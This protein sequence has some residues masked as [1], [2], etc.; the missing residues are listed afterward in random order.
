MVLIFLIPDVQTYAAKKITKNLNESYGTEISL[1]RLKINI[2]TDIDLE[3]ALVLDHKKDTLLF[4]EQISTSIFNI[5]NLIS[6]NNLDLSSTDIDG[7][8]FNLV[9]YQNE[10]SNNLSQ[11]LDKLSKSDQPRKDSKPF[12]LHIDD[13]VLLNSDVKIINYKKEN[14]ELFTISD[15]MLDLEDVNIVEG[16]ISIGINSL[17]GFTGFGMRVERLK[18][19]F[20]FTKNEM[21][22]DNLDLKTPYSSISTDLKFSFDK[23]DWSD[24]ENKVII[25]ADFEND[26]IST[27]DLYLFYTEFG[28]SEKLFVSGN[29]NGPL[30]DFNLNNA[31]IAGIQRSS[32]KGNLQFKNL[33]DAEKFIFDT[34]YVDITT[35]YYDLKRLLPNILGESLP[36]FIKY[37]GNF[38]VKGSTRLKSVDLD[39]DLDL[40]SS[41]GNGDIEINFKNLN[42]S[43]NVE[44]EGRL[45]LEQFNLG[46]VSQT[47]ALGLS[48]FNVYVKGKGFTQESLDTEVVG[49]IK[50]IGINNYNYT[51]IDIDGN[52]KYPIFDGVLKS[53]DPNFL[54]DFDGLVDASGVKNKF[55]FKSKILYADLYKL[56]LIKK[57]ETAIFQGILDINLEASS[58]DDAV[59]FISFNNFS[60]QNSFDNYQFGDLIIQS[61]KNGQSQEILINSP[62]VINGRLYGNYQLSE[63]PEFISVSLKNLYFKNIVDRKFEDKNINFEFQLKNKVVEAFFPNISIEA[64]T[65]FN[66]R[67]SSNEDDMKVRFVSPAIRY[68]NNIFEGVEIQ[69]DKK[70]PYF[71]TYIEIDKAQNSVY[72]MSKINLI[73]VKLN[74]TLFFRTEFEGGKE[75]QDNYKLTFYQTFDEKEN[76][77]VGIQNSELFFKEKIWEINREKL[78]NN[79]IILEPGLQNFVFDSIMMTHKNHYIALNGEVRDST[80][81][82]LN[83]RLKQV[84]LNN[85]TPYID[86][87]NL[88]GMVNGELNLYQKGNIYKPNLD[89]LIRDFSINDL[90]Y[91]NLKLD[92]DGN[93]D[94]SD[95]DI[96]AYISD[97]QKNY[98]SAQ[99]KIT[100][101]SG[102]QFIDVDADLNQLD[103]SSLSP[104]G[105][106]IINRLRGKVTGKAEIEG[107]LNNPD[108]F[109]T[110]NLKNAGLKFPYLNVDFDFDD[111]AKIQLDK[112]DFIFDDINLT[113]VKYKTESV[114]SGSISHDQFIKWNLDLNL[115]ADNT[116]TLDTKYDEESLYYGTAFISGNA[117]IK[118]PTDALVIDVKAK[119]MPNTVFNIPLSDTETVGDSSFIYFLTPE[120][121]KKLFEGKTYTFEE[122][123]GLSLTFDLTVTDDALVEVVIDQESGSALRGRGNGNIKLEITTTGKFDMYG[124]FNAQSGEYI[125]KYQGLVEK[126]LD[127]VPGGYISWDGDP[128]DAFID[129][130]ANYRAFANPAVLLD[131]PSINREIPIDV[132]ILLQGELMQP[133]IRFQLDYPNLSSIIKSELD[134]RVQG[135]ENMQR[136]A[137][138]LLV[139]GSFYNDQGLGINSLGS[140][141]I[142]ERAT[143]ILD[144]ILKDEDGEFNI[145]LDYVPAE[146]T[147]NQNAVG[148]DRVGMKLQTQLSDKIFINGRFGVPVGGETQSFVFGDVELN[149]LLNESGSLSAQMFNRESDIQFI[150]EELGYAQ[151]IGITYTVDFETFGE[152]FRKMLN[153]NNSEEQRNK[154]KINIE[155]NSKSLVPDYIKLPN[156]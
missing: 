11:F 57:D 82:D 39:A 10:E 70:N 25:S 61:S 56:N 2:N 4:A 88:N 47:K 97:Q 35:N 1:D 14:P 36:E 62:D 98:L 119:S 147:P 76:T 151:G 152:L 149:F 99:G 89:V 66:G 124:D 3:G 59:G 46:K 107:P 33:V 148:S 137:I 45:N 67:I 116:L 48:S 94:L 15:L 12:N 132:V 38:N 6:E 83:L 78:G 72:N 144:Q 105:K 75:N 31:R 154:K 80:Y 40:S 134:F 68:K 81:K 49:K 19:N 133:D 54:F 95:F 53:S 139:Q 90:N 111:N 128:L 24:F 34:K 55:R 43:E 64:G 115:E 100:T 8:K 85:I 41:I 58:L 136:Q 44:Y 123:S 17:S 125:Y 42:S 5:S 135:Q 120:D 73:N 7:L 126:K 109:G 77:V 106:D 96:K 131:N 121:K 87:L 113:D 153:N 9:Q 13:L 155:G 130:E 118:G 112:K 114:L 30:N 20:Y 122:I 108:I 101:Q 156:Q 22:L 37:V 110:L 91:G 127:V 86:S 51:N 150:G 18:S 71:D 27:T 16:D 79:K 141:L 69:L 117:S 32:I 26:L 93:K 21:R 65:F 104:L 143:S 146:R 129:I 103:I 145:G 140:N 102:Q 92:A 50:N 28:I 142:A 138:S 74:D 23:G 60:Y 29:L 63:L 52:F 84:E